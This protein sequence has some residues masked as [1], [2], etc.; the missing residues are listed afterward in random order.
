MS[1]AE[2]AFGLSPGLYPF[3]SRF[4]SVQGANVHYVDEGSGPMLFMLHGNPTWSFLYRHLLLA[5][6]DRFR[7]IAIDLPGF[8]L[9]DPPAGFRFR[10][11]D[12]SAVVAGMLRQLDIENATLI[13]HDWGGPI[14]LAASHEE[15]GRITRLVLGNTWAWPVNGTWHFE[16]FSRSMGGPI[17]RFGV[18]RFNLFVNALMPASMRRGRLPDYV[19]H[20]YRAP[21]SD[22]ARRTGTHVFPASILRSTDFLAGI[23]ARLGE[24]DDRR[25][26]FLWPDRDFAFRKA[27]LERWRSV[28]P[29]ARVEVLGDCGHYLWEEAPDETAS[30]IQK[31]LS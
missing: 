21:F 20:A 13:A 9:S 17:G 2:T 15:P 19:M 16:W 1:H 8:G 3:E 12:H 22:P 6:R 10:P 18:S 29:H 5:L 4:V 27:E 25:V 23:A 26:L 11:E 28:F 7:C 14:G 24:I 30:A 31:W